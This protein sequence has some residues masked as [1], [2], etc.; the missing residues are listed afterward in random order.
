MPGTKFKY[1]NIN[2]IIDAVTASDSECDELSE[3]DDNDE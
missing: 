1:R 3:D 2:D